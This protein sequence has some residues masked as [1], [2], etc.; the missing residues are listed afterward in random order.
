MHDFI[1]GPQFPADSY[2][3]EAMASRFAPVVRM[4]NGYS[5]PSV[6]AAVAGLLTRVEN[7]S[8]TARLETMV[9]LAAL[10]CRGTNAPSTKRLRQWLNVSIY[11]D[12]T[13]RLE[14]PVED[15]A[16]SN[17]VTPVG[18]VRLFAGNWT[19][20][21][22]AVE[23]FLGAL[24]NLD[25]PTWTTNARKQTVALLK[26]SERVAAR[27]NVPRN[28]MAPGSAQ[29]PVEIT[30]AI[31]KNGR[32]C[33]TLS[34][35]DLREMG[36]AIDDV[37]PF[38]FS[39]ERYSELLAEHLKHSSLQR[40]PLIRVRDGVVVALPTAIGPAVVR[41]VIECA[42]QANDMEALQTAVIQEQG[43]A[44][45]DLGIRGWTITDAEPPPFPRFSSPYLD[46]IGRFDRD[47]PAHVIYVPDDLA[48]V[49]SDGM[50]AENT[51]GREVIRRI[52]GVWTTLAARPGYRRG[53][54]IVVHGGVG[55]AFGST[56]LQ[57][58][59][60]WHIL[61]LPLADFMLLAWDNELTAL[62]TWKFL[63]QEQSLAERGLRILNLSGFPNL[64]AFLRENDFMILPYDCDLQ[65]DIVA[66]PTNTVASLRRF[67]RTRLDSHGVLAPHGNPWLPVQRMDTRRDLLG[68]HPP[69][70]YGYPFDAVAG[71]LAACVE[72]SGHVWWMTG[73][74]LPESSWHRN[75]VYMVWKMALHWLV[76]LASSLRQRLRLDANR[77]IVYR[78]YFPG[79]EDFSRREDGFDGVK[80]P[81]VV[82]VKPGH[83]SISC[84]PQYLRVIRSGG[85]VG[86]EMMVTAMLRGA[87][88]WAGSPPLSSAETA[89]TVQAIMGSSVAQHFAMFSSSTPA[90]SIYATVALPQPRFPSQEDRAWSTIG[91]AQVAGWS[92]TDGMVPS[93]SAEPLMARSVDALWKRIRSRLLRLDRRSVLRRSLLNVAAVQKDRMEW[94]RFASAILTMADDEQAIRQAADTREAKRALAALASRVIAEMA[95]CTSPTRDGKTCTE[96][97]L[98]VLLGEV[99]TLLACAV[100][101]DAMH[102]GLLT[103]GVMVHANGS[104]GFDP[105]FQDIVYPYASRLRERQIWDTR[106]GK[107]K[108]RSTLQDDSGQATFDSAFV[109]EFGLSVTQYGR[110]IEL[111][112]DRLVQRRTAYIWVR[113][114]EVIQMLKRVGAENPADAFAALVLLPRDKW[115][116]ENPGSGCKSRD[117]Y[118]W[119]YGRR[120]SV[121]RRPL[122]QLSCEG[123][124]DVLLMPTLLETAAGHL[125]EARTGQ[126]T[127]TLF[128]S[129][130]MRSWIGAVTDQLGHAFNETVAA[131]LRD[132]GWHARTEVQ[133]TEL[134]GGADL[135]DVD[136]LAWREET[137]L[138]YA[139]ECKRLMY[140][141]TMGEIGRRLRDYTDS[142]RDG[143]RTP[144]QKTLDRMTFLR[145]NTEVLEQFIGLR[146]GRGTIRSALV[147]DDITPM[148]FSQR[149]RERLD[150]VVDYE[151]LTDH[152][153][154]DE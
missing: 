76:P 72:S 117:W 129:E 82:Q 78:L 145:N 125:L 45:W 101:K 127:R 116:E 46:A 62:R 44:V 27:A 123:D 52:K 58:P 80:S 4:L 29:R 103:K 69:P 141:R 17:V 154:T 106:D 109:A 16:V 148:Q 6:V 21:A 85:N 97:D 63:D 96:R 10:G 19:D 98:D 36:I 30:R 110:F 114:T 43:S 41:Y 11:N 64:Y 89:T 131:K 71:H 3:I 88:L 57:P 124:A 104:F 73:D 137:E 20:I 37:E 42:L 34:E 54:T 99:A 53:L 87:Y 56:P 31:V 61:A 121:L 13:T 126:L 84:Q 83:I 130:E 150:L 107:S 132:L 60:N 146:V 49:A 28:A 140:D 5:F 74:M 133:M 23:D 113:R 138:V 128:D 136:V 39:T 14:D 135:G 112:T 151:G 22:Y 47:S 7:H 152:F 118:P 111:V 38:I 92:G 115:D 147:T 25:T 90:E 65:T 79:I 139:I 143:K 50:H 48:V 105:S 2:Q 100:Q 93:S 1:D 95:L 40:R 35:N 67:L 70:I 120:L 24:P 134:G 81:P 122:V 55:R 149:V 66:L 94:R 102:F 77:P 108:P 15:V 144:I 119:R 142:N 18:N 51:I 59:A 8:A 75:L 26:I 33:V 153:A 9:H 86:E 68:D 12:I 32:A 91:L